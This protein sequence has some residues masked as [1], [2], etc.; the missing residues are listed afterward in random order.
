MN[1]GKPELQ[2]EAWKKFDPSAPWSMTNHA[3]KIDAGLFYT[4]PNLSF[5]DRVGQIASRFS[6]E[7]IQTMAGY[8]YSHIRNWSG[9]V[10]RV[11]FMGGATFVTKENS[12]ERSGITLGNYVNVKI[13]NEIKGD[14][15]TYAMNEEPMYMH[16]YGH[17]LQSM[18][19]GA[20]YLFVVGLPSIV[21]A[22]VNDS[23]G[24]RN[25]YTET[26]ANRLASDYF[27]Q[28]YGVDWSKF[29]GKYPL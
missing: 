17:V 4:D 9:E 2:K 14:F 12:K 26:N 25:F 1:F 28:Y 3:F 11:D 20:S 5:W 8:W 23:E 27:S 19:L 29:E 6:F 7:Y 16:E 13:W 15:E 22:A 10:D 18:S 21:S 24:H